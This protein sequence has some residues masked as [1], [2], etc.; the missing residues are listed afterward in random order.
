MGK[1]TGRK[2]KVVAR[3]QPNGQ[4]YRPPD[5]PRD[6][7]MDARMRQFRMSK[8]RAKEQ[9]AGYEIG[10]LAMAGVF[11]NGDE[12][13]K[14]LDTVESYVTTTTTFLR[15]KSP[16]YPLP[17]AMDYMAGRGASLNSDPSDRQVQ[18]VA[19][20]YQ[21]MIGKLM[22][23]DGLDRIVFHDVAFH[24]RTCGT[25]RIQAVKNCVAALRGA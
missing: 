12:T 22:K 6:V 3:R 13:R 17:R 20:Q 11:G 2:R 5:D 1:R 21:A 10:R 15:L 23:V 9:W 4:P 7:V 14:A 8:E 18:A 25:D 16:Q 19:D 24:D